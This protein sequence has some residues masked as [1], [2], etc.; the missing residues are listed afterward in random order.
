MASR[1]TLVNDDD[2]QQDVQTVSNQKHTLDSD[3]E[4]DADYERDYL[5]GS[6]VEGEEEGVATVQDE[7]KIT[8]FNMR[9]ELE[10]GHFDTE[11]NY[12]WS[13]DSDIHDNWLDNIDWVKIKENKK[14][15]EDEDDDD[16]GG[17]DM[18]KDVP[19]F[20]INKSYKEL[21]SHM[22][23]NETINQTIIRLGKSRPKLS[24]AQ[25]M[26]MK[27][28][29]KTDEFSEKITKISEIANEILSRTGNMDLYE[30][31]YEA[32]EEKINKSSATSSSKVTE[33]MKRP[34]SSDSIQLGSSKKLK[35]QSD[36]EQDLLWEYKIKLDDSELHG[37]FTSQQM[38]KLTEKA[39]FKDGVYVKKVGIDS[40][41][42]NSKR[43]DFDLYC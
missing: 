42:Y 19:V 14:Q 39:E 31:S 32:I 15:K 20:D 3:E 41:F 8:P 4:D 34:A 13:K 9:E 2:I 12:H 27:K 38:L 11:G 28:L 17:V 22:N 29:N 6:D 30:M 24:T 40:S 7:I 36:S 10:E 33:Q 16:D 35:T 5:E 37:P 26:K 43:I 1:K 21:L 18:F 25:R 23:K